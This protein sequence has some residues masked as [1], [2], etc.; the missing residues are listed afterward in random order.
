MIGLILY[1]TADIV[2][3]VSKIGYNCVLYGVN[4]IYGNEK[5]KEDK[6]NEEN[7]DYRKR[8]EELEKRL[9]H[10]ERTELNE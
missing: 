5:L 4:M 8:I 9:E 3:H 6:H 2:F 10:L 1:E 7:V